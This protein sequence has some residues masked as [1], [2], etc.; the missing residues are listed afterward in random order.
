MGAPVKP[1]A[2]VVQLPRHD[3]AEFPLLCFDGPHV[4]PAWLRV[5]M[6]D[7]N[8]TGTNEMPAYDADACTG[9]ALVFELPP[10]IR[11]GALISLLHHPH[12]NSLVQQIRGEWSEIADPAVVPG[13]VQSWGELTPAGLSMLVEL[14]ELVQRITAPRF[15]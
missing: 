2:A 9:K 11:R 13:L 3:P 10:R 1:S 8:M 15:S 12:V 7:G 6:R 4:V 14:R 5:D